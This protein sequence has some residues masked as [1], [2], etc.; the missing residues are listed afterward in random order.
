M[1]AKS[2][3]SPLVM[4]IYIHTHT[5]TY[6]YINQSWC[7]TQTYPKNSPTIPFVDGFSEGKKYCLISSDYRSPKSNSKP[8]LNPLNKSNLW[9]VKYILSHYICIQAARRP[10]AAEP[11][12][13]ASLHVAPAPR[14]RATPGGERAKLEKMVKKHWK[15]YR[16][17]SNISKNHVMHTAYTHMNTYI[18]ICYV[19]NMERNMRKLGQWGQ[20][21]W[22]IEI[23]L[24]RMR[25]FEQTHGNTR[26]TLGK[27]LANSWG[28]IR[29]MQLCKASI[30]VSGTH[31]RDHQD[32]DHV[33]STC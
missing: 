12:P 21:M 6:I 4:Y 18:Y 24:Q 31:W 22:N 7:W 2:P 25:T 27:K 15:T 26:R 16:K 20:Y 9:L 23:H 28:Y 11:A 10:G 5:H 8:L 14:S 32:K 1:V 19:N 29:L 3:H 30:C 33:G 17:L 13:G